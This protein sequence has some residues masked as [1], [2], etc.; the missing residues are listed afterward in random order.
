MAATRARSPIRLTEA[1]GDRAVANT[2]ATARIVTDKMIQAACVAGYGV[3]T[4]KDSNLYK[5]MK[6]ALH[7]AFT[8]R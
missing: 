3:D 4:D 8:A 2:I 6:R 1:D 5:L 7:A